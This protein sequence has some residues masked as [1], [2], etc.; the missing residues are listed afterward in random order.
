MTE[1]FQFNKPLPLIYVLNNLELPEFSVDLWELFGSEDNFT[2][3]LVGKWDTKIGNFKSITWDW[4]LSNIRHI[5][6]IFYYLF[7]LKQKRTY[8]QKDFGDK[9]LNIEFEGKNE[10]SYKD[11]VIFKR[12]FQIR[13]IKGEENNEFVDT[14]YD[15]ALKLQRLGINKIILVDLTTALWRKGLLSYEDYIKRWKETC[16]NIPYRHS[17]IF[18]VWYILVNDT[19]E[20][21]FKGPPPNKV[22]KNFDEMLKDLSS[23]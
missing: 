23:D 2:K 3:A 7:C 12:E 9:Y 14:D 8:E 18:F 5:F 22:H 11:S 6:N 15:F 16:F 4:S 1:T 13:N 19:E 10:I 20:K 21:F 17:D